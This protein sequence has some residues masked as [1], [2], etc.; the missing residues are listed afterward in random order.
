MECAA[1]RNPHHNPG[2]LSSQDSSV[3]RKGFIH[4]QLGRYNSI[5]L[6]PTMLCVKLSLLWLYLRIFSLIK[7]TKYLIYAGMTFCTGAYITIMFVNIFAN[8]NT[9]IAANKALGVVNFASDVYIL[10]VPLTTVAKLQLSTK[11]KI[12]ILLVFMTGIVYVPSYLRTNPWTS[13]ILF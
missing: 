3:Q 1:I 5:I 4:L 2:E 9:L 6:P 8:I 13:L 10:F 7:V 12:G 11:R